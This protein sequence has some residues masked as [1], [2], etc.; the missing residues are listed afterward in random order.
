MTQIKRKVF[1]YHGFSAKKDEKRAGGIVRFA[2]EN[3]GNI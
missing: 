2:Q 1:S 3:Q